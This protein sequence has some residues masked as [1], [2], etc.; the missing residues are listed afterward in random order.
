MAFD[1]L[2]FEI[3]GV[4]VAASAGTKDDEDTFGSV[5]GPNSTADKH[6]VQLNPKS[7]RWREEDEACLGRYYFANQAQAMR[8]LEWREIQ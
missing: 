6:Y 7:P 8:F 2:G 4:E 1:K 3:P 5:L